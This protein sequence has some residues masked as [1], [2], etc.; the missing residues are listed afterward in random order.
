MA[1]TGH[2]SSGERARA[3][4]QASEGRHDGTWCCPAVSGRSPCGGLEAAPPAPADTPTAT[5]QETPSLATWVNRPQIPH[6]RTCGL[7]N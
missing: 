4:D 5:S 2:R 7:I 6:H 1:A 3:R